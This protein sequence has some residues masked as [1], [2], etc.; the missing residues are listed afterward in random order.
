MIGKSSTSISADVLIQMFNDLFE[1]SEGTILQG[2]AEEPLYLPANGNSASAK[3][4]FTRDYA[5]SALH[6]VAHWCLAGEK[7]RQ[8]RDYGYWYHAERDAKQQGEFERSEIKPQALESVFSKA[9]SLPF[10]PSYD[11][12]SEPSYRSKKFENAIN[13]Q[14]R[15]FQQYGLPPRAAQFQQALGRLTNASKEAAKTRHG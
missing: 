3:I 14:I 13:A 10:Q 4:V 7:R 15:K 6:E 8:Q 5:S 2:G 1:Y 9:C 11:R 12:L